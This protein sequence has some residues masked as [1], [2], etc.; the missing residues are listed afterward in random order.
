VYD[1]AGTKTIYALPTPYSMFYNVSYARIQGFEATMTKALSDYW[2]ARLGYT[3]AIA[4]GT[5]SDPYSAYKYD[6]YLAQD[7]RHAAHG[8]LGFSFPSDFGFVVLRD[9]NLSGVVGY[10]SGTPYTPTDVRGVQ[11]GPQN[12]ARMPGTFNIDARASKELHLGGLS[13]TLSCDVT[14]VAN[15]TQIINVFAA[16]GKPDF[17]GR[18]ITRYE[19]GS[20]IAFGDL[21][22]HPYRDYNHDGYLDQMEQYDSYVRAYNN[23][24]DPPTYYGPPRKVRFG[25]SMSF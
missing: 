10:G 4:K 2:S 13:F 24:N 20:G 16:T 11:T 25:L 15:A 18:T 23:V 22:Y 7:Q 9:F 21:Y 12:S 17:T 3:F 1:L 8:D 19:F 6:T 5:A 14:N